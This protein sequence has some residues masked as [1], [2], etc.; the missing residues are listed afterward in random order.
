MRLDTL[1]G[2]APDGG[3]QPPLSR[4]SSLSDTRTVER[5]QERARPDLMALPAMPASAMPATPT[6]PPLPPLP[7][8]TTH[9][10]GSDQGER[11][12]LVD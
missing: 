7:P 4:S 10:I 6:M 5:E 9:G 11:F 2:K 1:Y 12:A 8:P 3:L